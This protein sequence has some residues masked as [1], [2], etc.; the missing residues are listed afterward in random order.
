M[1]RLDIWH[2]MLLGAVAVLIHGDI[3]LSKAIM[4]INIDVILFL[5]GMFILGQA[6]EESGFLSYLSYSIFKNAKSASSLLF[7]VIFGTGFLSAILMNDTLAVVGT[8]IVIYLSKQHGLKQAS[9]LLAL[10]FS[11]T[12]G[13]VMSPIGNPQN[14]LIALHRG[15]SNPF[16]VFFR[17]LFVPTVL[18]LFIVFF[19]IKLFYSSHFNN[20]SVNHTPEEIKDPS[21]ALISKVSLY[22]LIAMIIVK[23]SL[24][25]FNL[26]IDFKLT[27]IAL[28]SAAPVILFSRRRLEVLRKLDWNTLI[29]FAAMFI[30][31]QSVWDTGFFQSL[32]KKNGIDITS[33]GSILIISVIL[34]QFISN[35]PLV[36]LYLPLLM[37]AGANT[38]ELMALAAGSTIA[39]N[40]TILGAASNVIIIQNAEKRD[41]STL[42]FLR[43]FGIGLPLTLLNLLVYW[44][45]FKLF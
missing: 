12:I 23:I 21:L 20:N 1:V 39:G 10:A 14:L 32:I 18:N 29:F 30:L 45:Y 26:D 8:P 6:L 17:Y 16:I 19:V 2:A 4:S 42:T 44:L 24:V 22:I 38:K 7:H 35:V 43:F 25:I 41:G 28:A 13:S 33:T 5:F 27:Y 15:L 40:L 34:S 9:M 37:H 36:A 11:V 31:M 3:T